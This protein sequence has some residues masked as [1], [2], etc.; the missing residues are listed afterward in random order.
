M[1]AK[2]LVLG[3]LEPIKFCSPVPSKGRSEGR[4]CARG[5]FKRRKIAA[6]R[7]VGDAHGGST[8]HLKIRTFFYRVFLSLHLF[9]SPHLLSLFPFPHLSL[10]PSSHLSFSLLIFSLFFSLHIFG[11]V[12]SSPF[13]F[14]LL[15]S[16]FLSLLCLFSLHILGSAYGHM[17]QSRDLS[18]IIYFSLL[19]SHS[20]CGSTFSPPV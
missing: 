15:T 1:W 18:G 20:R 5:S 6:V 8:L 9:L 4:K 11:S 12:S 13:C 16:F 10:F 7:Y 17:P 3:F 19:T 14:S 2:G